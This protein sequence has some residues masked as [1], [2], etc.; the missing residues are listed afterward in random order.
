MSS[1]NLWRQQV[2]KQAV[3]ALNA[4]QVKVD[5]WL[6]GCVLRLRVSHMDEFTISSAFLNWRSNNYFFLSKA[7]LGICIEINLSLR[8]TQHS[9]P[10]LPAVAGLWPGRPTFKEELTSRMC[11]G[12]RVSSELLGATSMG[13]TTTLEAPCFWGRDS[14]ARAVLKNQPSLSSLFRWLI[15]NGHTLHSVPTCCG[16]NLRGCICSLVL[17]PWTWSPLALLR[18][19]LKWSSATGTVD[20][21]LLDLHLTCPGREKLGGCLKFCWNGNKTFI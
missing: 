21:K 8:V 9:S 17:P 5:Q 11:R 16:C 12:P 13:A 7:L 1:W 14:S 20:A 3:L 10:F 2:T 19:P 15:T 4:A 18:R 6:F